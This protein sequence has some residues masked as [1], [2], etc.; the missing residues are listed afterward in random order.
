M[1]AH[2]HKERLGGQ[3]KRKANPISLSLSAGAGSPA[4]VSRSRNRIKPLKCYDYMVIDN[5]EAVTSKEA[6]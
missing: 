4:P 2:L 5:N 3:P 6:T 1:T